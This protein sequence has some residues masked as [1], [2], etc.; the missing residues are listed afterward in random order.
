MNVL[1]DEQGRKYLARF[2]SYEAFRALL[3][4]VADDPR[5]LLA[6]VEYLSHYS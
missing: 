1:I 3:G 5:L 6:G 4:T 2:G